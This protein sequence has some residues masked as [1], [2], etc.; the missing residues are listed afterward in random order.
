MFGRLTG[1]DV[2]FWLIAFFG[3]IVAVNA[4]FIT[5]SITTFRG[6][7]EQKPYLQGIEYNQT[8]REHAEQA[9]L[10]W[11]ASI[12]ASRIASGAVKIVVLLDDVN[13]N[14]RSDAVL[15]GELRHPSDETR[16]HAIVLHEVEKGRYVADVMAV[17]PGAWDVLI[18]SSSKAEPFD[19]VRRVWIP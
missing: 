5:I 1:R 8:L 13:G 10:N 14:P 18:K 9:R 16:D 12:S 15:A 6:E 2:L 11:T 4:Y 3:L 17:A 7:D 19:A